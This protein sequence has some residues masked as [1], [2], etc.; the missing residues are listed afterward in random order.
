MS[1]WGTDI[2]AI[3]ALVRA[4]VPAVPSG[5][6][7]AERDVRSG[8]DL[9]SDEL[10]HLFVFNPRDTE[11]RLPWAQ[12]RITTTYQAELWADADQEAVAGYRDAI[13]D[14]VD[15]DPDLSG[16]SETFRLTSSGILE[17]G[18]DRGR[19]VLLLEFEVQRLET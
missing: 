3:V 18:F 19:R 2:A 17:E 6:A 13:R 9:R 15:G 5:A 8:A 7:G 4:A 1:A 10:P 14:A 16:T 11:E 12:V